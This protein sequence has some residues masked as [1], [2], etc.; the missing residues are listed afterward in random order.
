MDERLNELCEQAEIIETQQRIIKRQS[1]LIAELQ[2]M[3]NA[4]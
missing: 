4:N 3:L 1:I 2:N